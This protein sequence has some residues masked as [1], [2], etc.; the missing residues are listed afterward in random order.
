MLASGT[1][2]NSFMTLTMESHKEPKLDSNFYLWSDWTSAYL[3]VDSVNLLII[4][5][6]SNI[7]EQISDEN[8]IMNWTKCF[9][10]CFQLQWTCTRGVKSADV[11]DNYIK[12]FLAEAA[13]IGIFLL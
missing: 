8:I 2:Y 5:Q 3:L 7:T 10:G 9:L 13:Y 1:S 12:D 4:E 6:M 11:G